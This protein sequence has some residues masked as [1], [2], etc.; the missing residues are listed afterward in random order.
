MSSPPN[1]H[2]RLKAQAREC[3]ESDRLT[4][5][6]QIYS[7]LLESNAQDANTAFDVANLLQRLGRRDEAVAMLERTVS[8]DPH[9]YGAGM[10]LGS[11][12]WK[13]GK[14]GRL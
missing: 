5:A 7:G 13:Q 12:L 4:D 6:L 2:Q 11:E 1:T 9:H 10:I 3:I 14:L 8:I